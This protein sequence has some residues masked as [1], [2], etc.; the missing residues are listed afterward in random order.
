MVIHVQ[1]TSECETF[2]ESNIKVIDLTK[3]VFTQSGHV[4]LVAQNIYQIEK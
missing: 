2:K 1:K 4:F 3:I